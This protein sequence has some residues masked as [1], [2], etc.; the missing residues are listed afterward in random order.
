MNFPYRYDLPNFIAVNRVITT[1][2]RKL[3]KIVK[4]HPYTYFMETDNTKI[5]F[6]N[7]GLHMNN[8]G[9]QLVNCQIVTLVYSI[10]EQK[11]LLL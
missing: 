10:I 6:T 7:H 8:L 4:A 11:I 5:L 2:N 1:L 3:K 9:K